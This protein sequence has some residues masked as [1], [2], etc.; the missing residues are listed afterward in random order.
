MLHDFIADIDRY[1]VGKRRSRLGLVLFTQ[2]LWACAV[3]RF[4]HPLVN[5]HS[6]WVKKV[7]HIVSLVAIKWIEVVTGISLPPQCKIGRG[8]YISHFGGVIINPR[9]VIG[10][11]CNIGHGVTIGAGNR[12]IEN[13]KAVDGV[14]ILMDRVYIGPGACIFGDIVISYD[15]A[16][17]ANAVVTKPLPPRAIAVGIPSKIISYKGSFDYVDYKGKE[18]DHNRQQSIR[19]MEE[20]PRL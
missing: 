19:D 6:R 5:H 7:S 11:N 8:L 3:Y 16:I 20:D 10:E 17:G 12:F 2:G 4:F 9:A 14:P 1:S 15:V 13:N 18:Q